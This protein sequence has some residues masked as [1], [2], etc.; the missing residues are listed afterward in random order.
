MQLAEE[1]NNQVY[2]GCPLIGN[3]TDKKVVHGAFY[4]VLGWDEKVRI[5]DLE[6]DQEIEVSKADMKKFR[7]GWALTYASA[8]SRTLREHVRLWDTGHP[9]FTK[10]HLAMGLARATSPS[11][12]DL[13]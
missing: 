2:V 10:K 4:K 13:A 11:L 8:Q 3:I 12:V 6:T 1:L 7:Y 5:K 9:H